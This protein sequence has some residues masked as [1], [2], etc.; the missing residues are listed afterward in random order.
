MSPPVK[1][2]LDKERLAACFTIA[3]TVLRRS[4]DEQIWEI[5]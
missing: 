4:C 3:G 5:A 2:C 1:H